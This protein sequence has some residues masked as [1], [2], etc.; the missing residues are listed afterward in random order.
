[1]TATASVLPTTRWSVDRV[2]RTLSN[3]TAYLVLTSVVILTL[4]P[5]LL[6]LGTTPKSPNQ[7]IHHFW[8]WDIVL[9]LNLQQNFSSA[10]NYMLPYLRNT[11]FVGAATLVGSLAT[12]SL[13][14]Y[15]FARYDFPAKR[16]IFS[17]LMFL[18]LVPGILQLIP[19]F[20]WINQLGLQNT[21]WALILP[22][23]AAGQAFS[24]YMMRTFFESQPQ[25]LFDAAKVDGANDFQIFYR[26]ALPLA[27]G[28]LVTLGI[29][30][31]QEVWNDLIW[32]LIVT[33]DAAHRTITVALYS[34]T[35]AYGQVQY[36]AMFAG[37]T[38]AILP[39]LLL[40]LIAMRQFVSGLTAGAM[41]A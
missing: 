7:F 30:R 12:V 39:M 14:G 29:L 41:K 9:P 24:V 27:K 19:A 18:M 28:I 38:I 35:G 11:I 36:G 33:K 25:A 5:F 20:M 21:Y 37:Y 16:F 6:M 2:R 8:P 34:F 31:L 32:P 10:W 15:A 4:I 23:T 1:M 17:T 3:V 40:F 22:Y 26:I 13:C